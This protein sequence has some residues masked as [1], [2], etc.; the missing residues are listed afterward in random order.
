MARDATKVL[1]SFFCIAAF[2]LMSFCK[3]SVDSAMW[4]EA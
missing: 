2:S 4:V 1:S 3:T